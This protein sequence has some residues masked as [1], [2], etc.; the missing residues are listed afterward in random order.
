MKISN[1]K[2]PLLTCD[3]SLSYFFLFFRSL[4]S[5][6]FGSVL[7]GTSYKLVKRRNYRT[8]VEQEP[9]LRLWKKEKKKEKSLS[10]NSKKNF[11]NYFSWNAIMILAHQKS[12]YFSRLLILIA[13]NVFSR[14][15]VA[16]NVLFDFSSTSLRKFSPPSSNK[17]KLSV[18]SEIFPF[19]SYLCH[20]RKF[21]LFVCNFYKAAATFKFSFEIFCVH[22]KVVHLAKDSCLILF[23]ENFHFLGV[24][25]LLFNFKSL[26]FCYDQLFKNIPLLFRV[27][28]CL[29]SD[30]WFLRFMCI[31]MLSFKPTKITCLKRKN[32]LKSQIL[33]FSLVEAGYSLFNT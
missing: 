31:Q 19:I 27:K 33:N 12:R 21:K 7:L 22:W 3:L 23:E 2:K 20:L 32:C 25:C 30:I 4:S 11:K 14:L 18:L 10:R 5:F 15:F 13:S 24:T 8:N 29:K 9:M 17:T 26:R 1:S 6:G 16:N 28:K